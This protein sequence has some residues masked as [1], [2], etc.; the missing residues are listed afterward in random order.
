MRCT[1]T[2]SFAANLAAS[3][4]LLLCPF[5]TSSFTC[6]FSPRQL[7]RFAPIWALPSRTAILAKFND[8]HTC[9]PL[10]RNSNGSHTYANW[11][12]WGG[13]ST[14]VAPKPACGYSIS[15]Q[16]FPN[17]YAK[18]P[19]PGERCTKHLNKHLRKLEAQACEQS[20]DWPLHNHTVADKVRCHHGLAPNESSEST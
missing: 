19:E 2:L 16:L 1:L 20:E 5:S 17:L 15:S 7:H 4:A 10:S 6:N 14:A 8:S 9:S 18:T 3:P 12:G 11:G 13:C